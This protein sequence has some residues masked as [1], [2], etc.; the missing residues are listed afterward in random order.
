MKRLMLYI[1]TGTLL[2]WSF[3]SGAQQRPA[4]KIVIEDLDQD[5]ATCGILKSS[6]ESI[7]A[8]TLRNNGIQVVETL[9][10]PYFYVRATMQP[11][12]QGN[13][14]VGCAAYLGVSLVASVPA[15]TGRF[16]PR[17]W[18]GAQLCENS[19]ILSG[20]PPRFSRSMENSLE[21][22]IKFCLGSLDY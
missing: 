8:L 2:L 22:I 17:R 11:I 13:Q 14:F 18:V 21:Q 9:T 16:K 5:A 20:A 1:L 19:Q 6:L 10:N 15:P 3:S 12:S 7:A 4:V